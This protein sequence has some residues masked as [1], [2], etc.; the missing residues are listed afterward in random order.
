M[1]NLLLEISEIGFIIWV[2]NKYAEFALR[3]LR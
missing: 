2:S 3:N 1:L